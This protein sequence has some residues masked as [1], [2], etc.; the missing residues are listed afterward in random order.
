MS[1]A[2]ILQK[3]FT[4]LSCFC[5][6]YVFIPLQAI[7]LAFRGLSKVTERNTSLAKRAEPYFIRWYT[8]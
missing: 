7:M 1:N 6:S 5:D 3:S 4:E 2:F 8:D